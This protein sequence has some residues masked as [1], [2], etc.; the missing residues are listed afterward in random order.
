MLAIPI[1]AIGVVHGGGPPSTDAPELFHYVLGF[2]AA[3]GSQ[4]LDIDETIRLLANPAAA[5]AKFHLF[6]I[7]VGRQTSSSTDQQPPR[8]DGRRRKNTETEARLERL[9]QQLK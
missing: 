3:I 9:A 5:N 1:I 4:F 7:S 8:P 2:S 6:W